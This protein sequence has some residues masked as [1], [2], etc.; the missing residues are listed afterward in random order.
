[1]KKGCAGSLSQVAEQTL[2]P[3]AV[4]DELGLGP[5]SSK[6]IRAWRIVTG[7]KSYCF[8]GPD[9]VSFSTDR[10]HLDQLGTGIFA[11]FQ[12][13]WT[14]WPNICYCILILFSPCCF[15]FRHLFLVISS[16][17]PSLS[18]YSFMPTSQ[19]WPWENHI[20]IFVNYVWWDGWYSDGLRSHQYT[21]LATGKQ[22]HFHQK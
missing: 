7:R 22:N 9:P 13:G 5:L 2:G 1:M 21:C 18:A 20:K 17:L 19:P 10:R 16:L 4:G 14:K 12:H 3:W 6:D 11:T 8:K 15:C